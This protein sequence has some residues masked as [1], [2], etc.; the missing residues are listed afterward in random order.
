MKSINRQIESLLRRAEEA[1][2]EARR[3]AAGGVLALPH[4]QYE[5]AAKTLPMAGPNEIGVLLA[6]EPI[7]RD[8]WIARHSPQPPVP[9]PRPEVNI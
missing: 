1:V 6:P 8:E 2:E 5:Q 3:A 4:E 9:E 7:T